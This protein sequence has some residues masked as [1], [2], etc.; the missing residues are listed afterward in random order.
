[1]HITTFV[2][3]HP[4]LLKIYGI[5]HQAGYLSII[6]EFVKEGSLRDTLH[7]VSD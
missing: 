3:D 5:E 7:Q 6:E 1:M 2:Q 4:Y